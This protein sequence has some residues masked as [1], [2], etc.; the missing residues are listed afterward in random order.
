MSTIKDKQNPVKKNSEEEKQAWLDA[1]HFGSCC[2]D[3]LP[4]DDGS[5]QTKNHFTE[6]KKIEQNND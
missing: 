2:S 6:G 3:P 5:K 1:V 4:G